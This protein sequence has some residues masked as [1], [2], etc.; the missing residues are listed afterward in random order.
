MAYEFHLDKSCPTQQPTL[1]LLSSNTMLAVPD[2]SR[3]TILTV[4]FQSEMSHQHM[5]YL[6]GVRNYRCLQQSMCLTNV[7]YVLKCRI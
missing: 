2:G 7:L 3:L 5:S 4:A 1:A 6:Q